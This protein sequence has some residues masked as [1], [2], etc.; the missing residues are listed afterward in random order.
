MPIMFYV[1]EL[2]D[3]IM[4]RLGAKVLF[5]QHHWNMLE[6]TG[7]TNVNNPHD[8]GAWIFKETS[9]RRAF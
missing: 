2:F 9:S 3:F 4:D 1:L 8:P 5:L 7:N 6:I